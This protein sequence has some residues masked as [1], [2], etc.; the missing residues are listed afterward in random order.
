MRACFLSIT[1]PIAPKPTPKLDQVASLTNIFNYHVMHV[2]LA[3]TFVTH[4]SHPSLIGRG[5]EGRIELGQRPAFREEAVGVP[6]MTHVGPPAVENWRH[7]G[8]PA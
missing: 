1:L 5:R 2:Q 8:V 7:S 3:P 6:A 4:G